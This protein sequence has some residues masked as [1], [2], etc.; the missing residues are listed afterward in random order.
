MGTARRS[1]IIEVPAE[2]AWT[3]IRNFSDP[4]PYASGVSSCTVDG[5]GVGAV[6][7]M[8]LPGGAE[9]KEELREVDE[10]A[11]RLSYSITQSPRPITDHLASFVVREAGEGR[12]EVEWS[13]RFRA[14][15]VPEEEMEATY[16]RIFEGGL[17]T[18]KE[19]LE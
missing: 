3:A 7:T 4:S 15:G 10:G 18:L 2:V 5:E 11:R 13:C 19:N 17:A 12:C 1:T 14:V 16:G 9:F 8:A 6:R